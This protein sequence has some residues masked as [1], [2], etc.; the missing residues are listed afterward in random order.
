VSHTGLGEV[1]LVL[2]AAALVAVLLRR[3]RVPP[4]VGFMVAGVAIGPGG[5][6]LVEDR[7]HIETLAE[8][9][10]ILLLFTV[11]LKLSL[12]DLWRLR[13]AVLGG[14]AA[15]VVLT[16]AAGAAIALGFGS[17]GSATVV[18]G[19]L[20][21][22]SST[23]LVLS[24]VEDSGDSGTR[25]GRSMVAVLLFQD[26]AV[27][28]IMLS[29][30][31]LA[32][33]AGSLGQIAFFIARAVAVLGL[34]IVV[35]RVVFPF[36][37]ERVV[38]TGSRELFTL[39]VFLAA[40]GTALVVGTFGI[41]M[42]LGA[43]LAG[44]VIS[45]SE[46]VS[47]IS[48]DLTPVRD[49]LNALFFAS[50]GMLVDTGQW[51][52]RPWLMLAMLTAVVIT[53]AVL[54]GLVGWGLTRRLGGG[55]VVGLGL[56]QVGEFSFIVAQEAFRLGLLGPL[57]FELFFAVAVPSM[58]LTPAL[59]TVARRLDQRLAPPQPALAPGLDGH[60]I[61]VGYGVNGRSVAHALSL[62]DVPHLVVDANPHTV[63]EIAS[64]G[65]LAL[66]GDARRERVLEATGAS[67]A[68]ALIAAIPDAASIR[69]V[70]A[71]ARAL[72]PKMTIL[73]RTRYLREVEALQELGADEVIPEEFETSLELTGRVLALYG[74][75]RRLVEREKA[76][77][78]AGQYGALRG[79]APSLLPLEELLEHAEL[80]EVETGADAA[81][82]GQ[83]LR[84]L[85][86]RERTG[87]S[88]V[89]VRRGDEV[90]ANPGPDL[91]L[92]AGDVLVLWG[93]AAQASDARTVLIE[94]S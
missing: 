83:T 44:M 64:R 6:G 52:A 77:L 10:V 26:L 54:A 40:L 76:A 73:A 20:V 12:G 25:E 21:A 27:I 15:Q 39:V 9:G 5:L 48:A 80:V 60:V 66:W 13:G 71:A 68:R 42:A 34:T 38:A 88:V 3:G 62:L 56:A 93:S 53:K 28:P 41:S 51:L 46:F 24:L 63:E 92:A 90:V 8:V 59:L 23:A 17:R 85:A 67:R 70:V 45:E 32:G 91:R 35:A 1:V 55:L 61:I 18:W 58:V 29:L 49:I 79:E 86:L 84:G 74:A 7:A 65:G 36:V 47:R 11:G 2:A 81:A 82:V 72:N 78:R 75:P 22:L 16:G 69:E 43:F 33:H 31:L 37:T 57:D 87:A 94:G 50:V 19:M 4:V 14:G 89:A 30:P